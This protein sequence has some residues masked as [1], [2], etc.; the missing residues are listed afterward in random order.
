MKVYSINRP[1]WYAKAQFIRKRRNHAWTSQEIKNILSL[2]IQ[3]IPVDEIIH[4]LR[5]KDVKR[6]QVYNI[7]RMKKKNRNGKCFQ[8]G[9]DLTKKEI[10]FQGNKTFKICDSCQEKNLKYKQKI[11]KSNQRKGFCTYC[12]TNPPLKDKKTCIHC[13]SYT[14]RRRIAEGMCG[15][16]GKRPINTK[17]STA[18]CDICLELNR[19][20]T[21]IHRKEMANANS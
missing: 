17:R 13:L 10:M 2:R 9:E 15:V 19:T 16:C 5:L 6:T 1:Q 21:S 3:Q 14:H 20:H 11:R 8:C 12:G 4:K 18:L 7:L